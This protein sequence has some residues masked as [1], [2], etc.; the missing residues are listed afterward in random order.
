[1]ILAG[2]SI[3]FLAGEPGQVQEQ[4]NDDQNTNSVPSKPARFEPLEEDQTDL[5][6]ETISGS[7][8]VGDIPGKSPISLKFFYFEGGERV[9]QDKFIL[10]EGEIKESGT[11]LID[12]TL[13]TRYLDN[14]AAGEDLCDVVILANNNGELGFSSSLSES[15]L[16]WKY[17]SML[18][19]KECF[20]L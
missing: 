11:S 8:F 3:V 16:A 19:H 5:I 14:L 6:R 2:L 18:K 20:G 1:M 12:L 13:H 7:E 17:K 10:A 9:W 4:T 15:Q